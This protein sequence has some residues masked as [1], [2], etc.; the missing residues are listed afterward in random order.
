MIATGAAPVSLVTVRQAAQGDRDALTG[1]FGR[2]TAQTRYRRFHG[3]VTMFPRRYLA[4]ALSRSPVHHALVASAVNTADAIVALASCRLVDEG[5]AEVGVLVEDAWQRHGVGSAL[6][7]E[8]VVHARALGLRALTA[9]LLTEQAWTAGLLSRY[10]TI[11]RSR[12]SRGVVVVTVR[13]APGETPGETSGETSGEAPA[14][15]PSD[16]PDEVPG[17][18]AQLSCRPAATRYASA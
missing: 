9:Q 16:E 13:L 17:D 18:P 4:E 11:Q 10:G 12:E 1:M 2:C 3:A 15:T 5:M 14:P 7:D 6:L 8:L